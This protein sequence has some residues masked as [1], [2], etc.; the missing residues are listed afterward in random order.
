MKRTQLFR[1]IHRLMIEILSPVAHVLVEQ[2]IEGEKHAAP[3]FEFYPPD[4]KKPLSPTALFHGL[5]AELDH[6]SNA[7][8][9]DSTKEAIAKIVFS[10]KGLAP[11]A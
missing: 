8:T 4:S 2:V 11:A 1:N 6:A 9:E 7:A 10:L 5:A 3:C